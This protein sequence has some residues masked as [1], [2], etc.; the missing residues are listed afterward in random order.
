MRLRSLCLSVLIF[1]GISLPASAASAR[2]EPPASPRVTYNFN[3]AWKFIREDV[4]GAERAEFD[5]AAWSTVSTPHTWNDIDSYRVWISH[6]SGDRGEWGGIGWYRKHFKLPASAAGEKV[7]VE[8]EGLK[9]AAHF[10]LNGHPMGK[11]ENGVTACGIDLTDFVHFGDADNVLAVKVDN[12][13]D[14]REEATGVAFQWMG[15]AF[16]P[17]FGGLNHDVWLHLMGRIH[18]TLPLH[19]NLGT[20]GIYVHADHF[21]LKARSADLTVEA[22]VRNETNDYAPITLSAVVVDH[23]GRVC[24]RFDSDASDLVAGQSEVFTA[25]GALSDAHFWDV[26][27]PYLYDVY[28]I[29]SVDGKV[30]DVARTRTGFRETAFKGGAGTGGVYLNGRFVWLTGFAQRSVNDWAGLGQAYPDWMHDYQCGLLRACHAN[31]LRWMHIAPQPVDVRACDRAGIVEVCPAGDKEADVQGR[32]WDQRVEVM[33]DTLIYYRNCPSIF[34][35][36]AGNTVVSPAHMEQMVALR[37][38]WDP[39]G[40]RVMG[41]RDNDNVAAN[42]AVTPIAEYYGVMVAQDPRTDRVSGSDIFRGYS[43]AR[44]DR[45]PLIETEDF[46]DEAPRGIWDDYS[47]PTFGLKPQSRDG[48]ADAY[49]WTSESFALA[50]AARYESYLANRIDH[51]DSIHAKWSGYASIYATDSNADGRQEASAVERLSG[52]LDGVRLP[53]E[54]YFVTRVMQSAQP[55]IHIIGHWTYPA[56]TRKTIYVAA[57]HCDSVELLVNGH[58]LGVSS[59]VCTFVD[60]VSGGRSDRTGANRRDLGSTGCIYAFPDVVFVPG[61]LEARSRARGQVAATEALETAGPPKAIRLTVRTGP[62]GWK[63]DGSDVA[64]IDVE[65]VDAKGRRCPTD[66]ARVDFSMAGSAIWRGGINERK[67]DSTN[68]RYLDTECGINRV[69][70][71]STLVPGTVAV[72]AA[73]VGLEPATI[74]IECRPVRIDAGR[75]LVGDHDAGFDD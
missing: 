39:S 63:A 27:N 31:Y 29:L 13:N 38:E 6:R 62:S 55:D 11:F 50:G 52:K 57:S 21:D 2:Y 37:K 41:V 30:V 65:V 43:L 70:L 56:G 74:R 17:N 54:L 60:Q 23:E 4:P 8:F 1:A 19:E 16:N 15:R 32:Q 58:S 68:H 72:T 24:A 66:E 3:P 47:P 33:R 40:G 67:L 51:T 20:T 28:S 9:Q 46:R 69:A 12:R 61:R 75:E 45:A 25:T 35:W 49:H 22:Q 18:Q 10:F 34:F 59:E 44:R 48:V 73:R 5:D 64:L 7:I 42:L 53:K 26:D 14:Y 36:E 71:R